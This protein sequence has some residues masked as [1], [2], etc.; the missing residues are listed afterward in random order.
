MELVDGL[1]F[2]VLFGLQVSRVAA[3]RRA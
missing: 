1:P 3:L 2:G